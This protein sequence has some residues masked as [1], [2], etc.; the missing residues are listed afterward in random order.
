MKSFENKR[1]ELL[2]E[3]Q[4]IKYFDV[5]EKILDINGSTFKNLVQKIY[6][7]W[8][9]TVDFVND[10]DSSF[11]KEN[12]DILV[13]KYDYDVFWILDKNHNLVYSRNA[14][15]DK[16]LDELPIE[17]ESRDDVF[18][19][20]FT[21]HF[22]H[23]SDE[24]LL[25]VHGAT[26]NKPEDSLRS[27]QA[28]GY[29]YI[30]KIWDEVFLRELEDA[31]KSDVSIYRDYNTEVKVEEYLMHQISVVK[32]LFGWDGREVGQIEFLIEEPV[33]SKFNSF[34]NNI[35]I[36]YLV[37]TI[38]LTVI[39]SFLLLKW[40]YRPLKLISI[41]LVNNNVLPIEKMSRKNNEF[42]RLAALIKNFFKQKVKL[43]KEIYQR[44]KT[45]ETLKKS[46]EKFR[47]LIRHLP[48]YVIL[49]QNE[50]IIFVNE[51]ACRK[52]KYS[53]EE[54]LNSSILSHVDE[55]DHEK[56]VDAVKRRSAGDHVD[57]Y[58]ITLIDSEGGRHEVIVRSSLIPYDDGYATLTVLVDI[59]VRKQFER[60][61]LES[62]ARLNAI[63]DNLP[64]KAWLKD[65]N[66]KYIAVN[67]PFAKYYGLE[68]SDLMGK[69][70]YDICPR[71][72]AS[73]FE[74]DDQ[75]VIETKM[76]IYSEVHDPYLTEGEWFET[77]KS[78]IFDEDG[79]VIG[80]AGIARDITE[81]KTKQLELIKAKED[82][83][84]ANMAK[85][86]FLS[87]MSHE[88]RTPLNAIIG[89]T[90][91]LLEE[92]PKTDQLENLN[93]LNFSADHLLSL[94]SDILDFSKIEAGKIDL[95]ETDF[96]L[97]DLLHSIKQT[98]SIKV[99]G[100][101]IAVELNMSDD[102]PRV[103]LGDS[104][105]LNQILTNLM[106]NAVKFTEKGTVSLNVS[107][108]NMKGNKAFL[109]FTVKD[110]GIGIDKEKLHEIFDPFMQAHSN[111]KY[112]VGGTGLGLAITKRLVELQKGS[113]TVESEPGQGSE[114]ICIIPYVLGREDFGRGIQK[115]ASEALKSLKNIRVL[116]VEDNIINQVIASKYLMKWGAVVDE[117]ENGL[118][119]MEKIKKN[120]YDIVLMDLQMPEMDGYE[121]ARAIRKLE[122][123][124]KNGIPIIA[125]TAS[126]LLEVRE[127]VMAVGMND[128]VTKPFNPVELNR[129]IVK[130][131]NDN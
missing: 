57:D 14:T 24:G 41:S 67:R 56:I 113:I 88:M 108:L 40:I 106:G 82:A 120:R 129:K 91:L 66:G 89:L 74:A 28:R 42:G 105:R 97:P 123:H 17:E 26:I 35:F 76:Q 11:A 61:I 37:L 19:N 84:A 111:S 22:H 51:E 9:G 18:A 83:D 125:L 25:E 55:K 21:L 34:A 73:K 23:L 52:F 95:E 93:T 20:N 96:I 2:Y 62:R 98:F 130:Y 53:K 110:S 16:S 109:R 103:L 78:P 72:I 118:V 5:Q 100:K 70:D 64:Y 33:I 77:F 29:L 92:N 60:E 131:V 119:A 7:I 71:E 85:Q 79:R 48:D 117:A 15:L 39:I 6:S 128:Y 99:K 75:R 86:Q 54:L 80:I 104:V 47:A 81:V 65:V 127:Q 44:E 46:E 122:D 87:T 115:E 101:D 36:L 31:S 4:K 126:A 12:F 13:T 107:L 69:T 121:T 63:L 116:L 59:T 8:D 27:L 58:E 3:E 50:K 90:N 114:F 49:H 102:L 45:E 43:E 38:F 10:P 112:N 94:I 124:D 1:Y 68:S 30:G 32:P